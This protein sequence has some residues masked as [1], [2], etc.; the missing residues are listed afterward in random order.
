MDR[1]AFHV[2]GRH[3]ILF[4][5]A[6]DTFRL[7]RYISSKMPNR[8]GKRNQE[9]M[10]HIYRVRNPFP[11]TV[12]TRCAQVRFPADILDCEAHKPQPWHERTWNKVTLLPKMSIETLTSRGADTTKQVLLFAGRC[13]RET[14]LETIPSQGAL[15][16]AR[17]WTVLFHDEELGLECKASMACEC[18]DGKGLGLGPSKTGAE[19]ALEDLGV[20][21]GL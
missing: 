14:M 2:P 6:S 19:L 7:T 17:F 21:S 8:I 1:N 20:R 11:T 9:Q 12:A 18:G 15:L 5:W 3:P 4:P 13:S 10:A 16:L